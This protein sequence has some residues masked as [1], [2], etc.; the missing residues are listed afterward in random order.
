M[1]TSI[2]SIV[3]CPLLI[4]LIALSAP[5]GAGDLNPP[6]GPV[7]PTMR[8]MQE[9]FD[10]A[11]QGVDTATDAEAAAI[12]A[13]EAA[14]NAESTAADAEAAAIAAQDPR[15]PVNS[16]NTPGDADSLFMIT[17]PGSYYL[18]ANISGEANKDGIEIA[19]SNVTLNLNG[20]ALVGQGSSNGI[21][22]SGIRR[23]LA[24]SN[25][26]IESWGTGCSA[27][28]TSGSVFD[29]LQLHSNSGDG[30]TVFGSQCRVSDSI[31][32]SNDGNGIRVNR[33]T[34][35]ERCVAYSN[36]QDGIR[37]NADCVI[38]H[39]S[40]ENNDDDGIDAFRAVITE[41]SSADNSGDGIEISSGSFVMRNSCDGNGGAGI[42]TGG[43]SNRIE[44]NHLTENGRGIEAT[45]GI[46]N[47]IVKNTAAGNTTNYQ[48][49]PD[50]LYGQIVTPS[51]GFNSSNAWANFGWDE[52]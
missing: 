47:L 27:Q 8:T 40:M 25:G 39:C 10:K 14:T 48:I 34:I 16:M 19:A 9:V 37:A 28:E 24:V 51:A 38:T 4:A 41:C 12:A 29:H 32:R 46:N 18:T 7:M 13:A 17:Q 1:K 3:C 43:D 30:L 2:I 36:G 50:N 20:F 5:V 31:S 22:V 21:L 23:N 45:A 42:R 26:T 49:D 35:V 44:S 6:I 33:A 11:Q 15:I 52:G